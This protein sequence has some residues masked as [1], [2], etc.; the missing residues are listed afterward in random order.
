[1]DF[2][3]SQKVLERTVEHL[4]DFDFEDI[5]LKTKIVK[6]WRIT[7]EVDNGSVTVQ[8]DSLVPIGRMKMAQLVQE[9]IL[10]AFE[11]IK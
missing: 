11:G 1:V 2:L 9:C 6:D 8:V 4:L 3:N 10:E 5:Q 7:I